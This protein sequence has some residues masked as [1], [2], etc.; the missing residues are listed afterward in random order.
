MRKQ[1]YDGPLAI[2][3]NVIQNLIYTSASGH[4]DYTVTWGNDTVVVGNNSARPYDS[5]EFTTQRALYREWMLV[6]VKIRYYPS[7]L[8]NVAGTAVGSVQTCHQMTTLPSIAMADNTL[9]A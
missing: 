9:L 5:S 6:G 8:T 4:G 7:A 2:K 3:C 1:R